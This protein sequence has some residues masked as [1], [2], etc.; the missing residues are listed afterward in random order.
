MRRIILLANLIIGVVFLAALGY[1][2]W[3]AWRPLAVTA[4]TLELPVSAPVTV[5]RDSLGVPHITAATI[6]DA[7]VAQ[8]FVTAQDRLFQMDAMRRLAAGEL[9]EVV[10]AG[11]IENDQESHNLRLKRVASEQARTLTAADRALMAAY[12]RGV[13]HYIATNRDKLPVEF[14][15]LG[16]DPRPW[17]IQ[18]SILT[19]LQMFRSLTSTWKDDVLKGQLR[20]KGDKEKVD[21]LFPVRTGNEAQLGSNA[22][23]VSGRHTASGKPI[24]A[25]DTHLEWSWPGAW[26][27][28]HLKAPGLNVAGFALPGVPTVIIGHNDRIAWG[29]T[30]LHYDVQD[31]YLEEFDAASGRYR[32]QGRIENARLEIGAIRIKGRGPVEVKHWVTRHGPVILQQGA[33]AVSIRWVASEPNGF[34]FPFLD[35]GKARNWEEF[36]SALRRYPGPA[37]NFLYADVDGNIGYRAAGRL[38]IRRNYSGDVPVSGAGENEWDGF[39]PFEKLPSAYNPESGILVT[40]NQ[41]PFNGV[42]DYGVNGNFASHY[43]QRQIVARLKAKQGWKPDDMLRIQTDVYSAFS[44]F[45]ARQC[46]AA[47]NRLGRANAKLAAPAEALKQWD[48]QMRADS[49]AA[50]LVTLIYQHVRR[51]IADKAAPGQGAAY[52]SQMAPAV[53]EKLLTRRPQGWFADYDAM[54]LKEFSDAVA[55]AEKQQGADPAKWTYGRYTSFSLSHPI[56]SRVPWAGKYYVLGPVPMHG[57]LTTVKQTSRRLGPSMRFV[58]DLSNWDASLANTTTGQSGQALSS[59]FTDQWWEY[60]AGRSF[61]MR[62]SDVAGD[63]LELRPIP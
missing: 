57:S 5:I 42:F 54:L 3:H 51:V 21:F 4:G 37:Q 2:W 55:E 11:G 32:F 14:K 43:R 34:D 19:G 59:H 31:L 10:G 9:A 44:H 24:L 38:P 30:N 47:W 39:I 40:A 60:L 45:L 56:L 12:A 62:F 18:D 49:S 41:N 61:P 35:I 48:G 36:Q 50:F 23:V 13:N 8:G 52:E 29:V 58:A 63:R 7:L 1:A 22:W 6:E 17:S 53:I 15:L 20:S 28:V 46:L 33:A 26:Y 27:M 16:Y 25:N